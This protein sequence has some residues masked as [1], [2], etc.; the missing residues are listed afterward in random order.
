MFTLKE[1]LQVPVEAK[2]DVGMELHDCWIAADRR[3]QQMREH[4]QHTEHGPL[5]PMFH[6]ESVIHTSFVPQ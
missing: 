1:G 2:K 6:K 5:S 4:C 3:G